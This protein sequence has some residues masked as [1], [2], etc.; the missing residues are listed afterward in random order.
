MKRSYAAN[1]ARSCRRGITIIEV[2]LAVTGV[3]MML[4]LCAVSIQLLMKLN[5]DVQGRYSA[6]VALER[7]ARQVRDDSHAS[8][9]ARI[10]LD[11]K[12]EALRLSFEPGHIVEYG[13]GDGGV[14]RTESRAGKMIRHETYA[15][16]PG[17]VGHFELRD[18]RSHKLVA[19][20]VTRTPGKSR[21]LPPRPLEVVAVQGKDRLRPLATQKGKP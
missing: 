2:L 18:E 9:T 8:A 16:P 5:S 3:A 15:L 14:V 13:S 11:K 7:L 19:L 17:E 6:A 20:V 1:S 10:V 21:A 12:P 4:T